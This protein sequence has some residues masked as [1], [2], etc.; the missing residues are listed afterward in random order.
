MPEGLAHALSLACMTK[1][2]LDLFD[3][4]APPQD[5]FHTQPGEEFSA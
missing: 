4:V 3:S 5:I 2:M 1:G